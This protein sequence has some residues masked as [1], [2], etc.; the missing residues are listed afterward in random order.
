MVMQYQ[1]RQASR[2]GDYLNHAR[3]DYGYSRSLSK[4]LGYQL[5]DVNGSY[6][7]DLELKRYLRRGKEGLAGYADNLLRYAALNSRA[8]GFYPAPKKNDL[9]KLRE[10]MLKYELKQVAGLTMIT[11]KMQIYDLASRK[12]PLM[13]LENAVFMN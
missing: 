13:N 10:K 4:G 11:P 3:G 6:G 5:I 12:K 1:A 2:T 8:G 9:Y 7:T